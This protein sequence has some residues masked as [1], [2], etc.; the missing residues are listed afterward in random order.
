MKKIDYKK[1]LKHLYG[2]SAKKV[3]VVDVPRMNFLLVDGEGDPN[4]AKAFGDAIE[5]LY[6][7]SYTLK[8]TVK[9]KMGVDYGVLPLE[10]LWW[11]DDMAVFT[12]G[13]K[14]AWKWTVMIMQPE[15]ITSAMVDEATEAVRKKKNPVSL[16]LVRFEAFEE[17]KAAQTLHIGPFSE[18]GPTVEKVH[19][20]IEDDGNHRTGKHHEIYLS[21][22]RRAAPE[23]WKT[24]VRQPM[25][26]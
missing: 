21:D 11:A 6:P 15:F 5:A 12:T 19:S 4:I 25:S 17:G 22:L 2:A 26:P 10:A 13:N 7:L 18:E 24:I 14:D 23:K 8:F 1:Q 16:P 9:E 3:E 20:F